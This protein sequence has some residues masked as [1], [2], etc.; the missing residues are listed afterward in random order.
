MLFFTR[1][2]SYEELENRTIDENMIE[3]RW[4]VEV[5]KV[6]Y[7]MDKLVSEIDH[8]IQVTLPGVG[9]GGAIAPD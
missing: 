1:D 8:D 6:W 7:V 2:P 4:G 3:V 5:S 9:T